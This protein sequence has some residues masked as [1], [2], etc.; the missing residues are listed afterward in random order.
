MI[1]LSDLSFSYPGDESP[2]ILRANIG[3]AAGEFGLICGPTGSGKSTLLRLMNGL[4]PHFV[5][6]VVSGE[7][8]IDGQNHTGNLP[9]ELAHLVGF[10]NQRPEDAFVAD[11]VEDELA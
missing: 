7:L 9:H 1:E 8:W 5:S 10:V 3:F 2:T 4:S 11:T 6:G